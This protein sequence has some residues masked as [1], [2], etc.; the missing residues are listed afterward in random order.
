MDK[1]QIFYREVDATHI[2]T[3]RWRK[4]HDEE[5]EGPSPFNP[6]VYA[7]FAYVTNEVPKSRKKFPHLIQT[8][9]MHRRTFELR[10]NKQGYIIWEGEDNDIYGTLAI[11]GINLKSPTVLAEPNAPSGFIYWG[12]LDSDSIVRQIRA[13]EI[14]RKA[15]VDTEIIVRLLEPQTLPKGKQRFSVPE[16]KSAMI[17][18]VI[19]GDFPYEEGEG[20]RDVT[21]EEVPK[22]T[23]ALSETAFFIQV[24]GLQVP[25]RMMDLA[26]DKLTR[27]Q[28]NEILAHVFQFVNLKE[29]ILAHKN[30]TYK[31]EYFECSNNDDIL[32]YLTVYLPTQIGKNY[33]RL[34]RTGLRHVFPHLGNI[35]LVGSIYDLD[36]IEGE[37]LNIDDNPITQEQI[38]EELAGILFSD[39]LH[40]LSG[41]LA[42]VIEFLEEKEFISGDH[43]ARQEFIKNFL[44]S[45]F[46]ELGWEDDILARIVPISN[47]FEGWI[48]ESAFWEVN[49]HYLNL[50][51]KQLGWDYH[52]KEDIDV[53]MKS[54]FKDTLGYWDDGDTD[55]IQ[56]ALKNDQLAVRMFFDVYMRGVPTMCKKVLEACASEFEKLE[57]QY[58][59]EVASAVKV[60]LAHRELDVRIDALFREAM[61]KSPEYEGDVKEKSE[62]ENF[63]KFLLHQYFLARGW[64]DFIFWNGSLEES[65]KKLGVQYYLLNLYSIG[66]AINTTEPSDVAS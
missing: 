60:M 44:L 41:G 12:L 24:R 27:E 20:W 2:P 53:F 6:A 28:F 16:L 64:D 3:I 39:E 65:L 38:N 54:F 43:S 50:V 26:Y 40:P 14:L 23:R 9:P 52:Y 31:P 35:S 51:I 21:Q 5:V 45:Y 10:F 62:R 11:K 18:E 4:I 29:E 46:Y 32:R 63:E 56:L 37:A 7:S 42:N 58:G 55:Q 13:S 57:S 61:E 59:R 25:E 8:S 33:G 15:G 1:E 36:S 17:Q 34:Y 48:E 66:K 19:K 30:P 22:L 49:E 47:V